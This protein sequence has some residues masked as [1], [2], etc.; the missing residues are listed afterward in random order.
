M[1]EVSPA[2]NTPIS[3]VYVNKED[4]QEASLLTQI[5]STVSPHFPL[6]TGAL[7]IDLALRPLS[8]SSLVTSLASAVCLVPLINMTVNLVNQIFSQ[9]EESSS[10]LKESWKE[11]KFF[12]KVSQAFKENIVQTWLSALPLISL[13]TTYYIWN[14]NTHDLLSSLNRKGNLLK[15]I[16][17]SVG[18]W[19]KSAAIESLA[20]ASFSSA[21]LMLK[22]T[23]KI[24][25]S[26]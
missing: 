14:G 17:L 24:L 1:I 18:L 2:V 23:Q 11:G 5:N 22:S 13:S 20:I 9:A 15:H 12:E 25:D 4:K 16:D 6:F 7:C 3:S 8:H 10:S 19:A 26:N 21:V